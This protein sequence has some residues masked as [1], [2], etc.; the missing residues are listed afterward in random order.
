[1][2][3]WCRLPRQQEEKNTVYNANKLF[4][5]IAPLFHRFCMEV[6][7]WPAVATGS[8]RKYATLYDIF[9][10]RLEW[11]QYILGEWLVYTGSVK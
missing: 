7:N 1:M 10:Q 8:Q 2:F 6:L 11:R 4:T 3:I 5:Y 9:D